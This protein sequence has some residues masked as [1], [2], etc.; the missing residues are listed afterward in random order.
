MTSCDEGSV[1]ENEAAVV[2]VQRLEEVAEA[3]VEV[4][5]PTLTFRKNLYDYR[6]WAFY[7]AA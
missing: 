6:I 2:V 5:C 1:G 3:E 4:A 7:C